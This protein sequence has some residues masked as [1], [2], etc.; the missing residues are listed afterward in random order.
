MEKQFS[1]QQLNDIA[2]EICDKYCRYTHEAGGEDVD[3]TEFC[4]KCPFERYL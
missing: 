2:A 4:D 3:I 1:I